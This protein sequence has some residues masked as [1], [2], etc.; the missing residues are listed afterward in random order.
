MQSYPCFKSCFKLISLVNWTSKHTPHWTG[1]WFDWKART[2]EMIIRPTLM[3]YPNV[4]L[5]NKNRPVR[6]W[7]KEREIEEVTDRR[8]L[9]PPGPP[10]GGRLQSGLAASRSGP[11]T[12]GSPGSRPGTRSA[13]ADC[14]TSSSPHHL[15]TALL[16]EAIE[17]NGM[18][19]DM[20][21]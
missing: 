3:L 2:N 8:I 18:I 4:S 11:R 20:V 12:P 5:F 16:Q 10:C 9:V 1:I 21:K 15:C 19:I 6:M 13:W 17:R 14:Y 7:I